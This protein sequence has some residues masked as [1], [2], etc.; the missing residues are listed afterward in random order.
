MN[1]DH[2]YLWQR[3]DAVLQRTELSVLYH[4]RR[5]R[6]FDLLDKCAK[7]IAVIGGSAVLA[8]LGDELAIQSAA[9]I[10]TISSTAALVGSFS[11]RARHHAD[12]ARSMRELEA[13]IVARGERDFSED[14]LNVWESRERT[15]EV[16]EPAALPALV[17][18][19]Q[20]QLA[21]ARGH[22]E[23]VRPLPLTHRLFAHFIA[24]SAK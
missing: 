10:I 23:S 9:A 22:P 11:E 1:S 3:R 18:L 16:A 17:T 5:E 24:F 13:A 7:G 6:F 8:Q 19:C 4:R 15:I 2:D 12:L 21:I 14:D 20:N